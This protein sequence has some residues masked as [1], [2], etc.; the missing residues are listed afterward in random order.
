MYATLA[1]LVLLLLSQS[2]VAAAELPTLARLSFWVAADRMVDPRWRVSSIDSSSST[3]PPDPGVAAQALGADSLLS[4]ISRELR[5]FA[6]P[7]ADSIRSSFRSYDVAAGPGQISR[8]GGG[9]R[10]GMRGG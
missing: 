10:R 3:I 7:G 1:P 6:A 4:R 5:Q 2:A 8:M 9:A